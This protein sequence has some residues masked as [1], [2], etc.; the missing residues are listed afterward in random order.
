M[1][2]DW[3]ENWDNI[4]ACCRLTCQSVVWT[5][6]ALCTFLPRFC[7]V[8]TW[9]WRLIS[10]HAN[11]GLYICITDTSNNLFWI[12][13]TCWDVGITQIFVICSQTWTCLI[14][15]A[16][17]GTD[18]RASELALDFM[19]LKE[20][21]VLPHPLDN[22]GARQGTKTNDANNSTLAE[23]LQAGDYYIES[24]KTACWDDVKHFGWYGLVVGVFGNQ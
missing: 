14:Q 13:S 1:S 16:C 5:F 6:S 9:C 3:W 2:S 10:I 19:I 23:T 24:R 21:S 4:V 8:N 15:T 17:V 12:V 20:V 22:L 11:S 18:W 7:G